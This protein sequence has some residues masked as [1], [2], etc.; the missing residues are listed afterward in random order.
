MGLTTED[1]QRLHANARRTITVTTDLGDTSFVD[2]GFC[3]RT[4]CPTCKTLITHRSLPRCLGCRTS[5]MLAVIA[6]ISAAS[7]L[8]LA[9]PEHHPCELDEWIAGIHVLQNQVMCRAALRA[10]PGRFTPM[11]ARSA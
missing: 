3:D 2:C 9:L 10:Y 8:F 6:C 11:V 4:H 1:C 5:L 7:N